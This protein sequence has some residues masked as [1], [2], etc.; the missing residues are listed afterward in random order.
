MAV[1]DGL[2]RGIASILRERYFAD[3]RSIDCEAVVEAVAHRD[4]LCL[5]ELSHWT[6]NLGWLL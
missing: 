4:R 6:T 1:R 5:D 3:P 2:Q